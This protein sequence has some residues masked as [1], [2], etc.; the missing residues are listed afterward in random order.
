[1]C[2]DLRECIY[3]IY[4]YIHTY[5][6]QKSNYS[7]RWLWTATWVLWP[8]SRSCAK[9]VSKHSW[10]AE[11]S[12]ASDS[13]WFWCLKS[14]LLKIL[15][16]W[17]GSY[18]Q[19]CPPEFYLGNPPPSPSGRRKLTSK[20]CPLVCVHTHPLNKCNLKFWEGWERWHSAKF[21]DPMLGSS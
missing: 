4:I 20:S 15:I 2:V 14:N 5:R 21:P 10:L 12:P 6:S 3:P 13:E 16:G 18:C 17:A 7:Y 11:P 1:M 19:A 9:P 8:K